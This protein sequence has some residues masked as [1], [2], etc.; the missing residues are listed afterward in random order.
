M[1]RLLTFL[2]L[3]V[4]PVIAF[5][6]E[7]LPVRWNVTAECDMVILPQASALPLLAGL[8]DEAKIE[9][10]WTRL[11]AM[12][13]RGEATLAAS[14]LAKGTSGEKC[15]SESIEEMKYPTEYDPPQV[16][17]FVPPEKALETLKAWPVVGITP[18]AFETRNVGM[19]LEFIGKVASDG[20]WI[21]VNVVPQ[22]V[23]FLRFDKFDAGKL[24]TGDRLSVEQPQFLTFKNTSTLVLKNGQRV[25]L[26]VHK[27]P[28]P[29][30]TMELFLLRVSAKK[31][32]KGK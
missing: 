12:I 31:V 28:S 30:T 9:T 16:P 5:A 25:L 8:N 21:D 13:D 20:E 26:G 29:E 14:L 3:Y 11:R 24:P 4:L 22:H 27:L 15:I 6:D 7:P 23:R 2:A 18:T 17:D 1:Q 19:T 10:G 32:A